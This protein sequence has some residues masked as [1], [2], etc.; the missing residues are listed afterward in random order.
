VLTDNFLVTLQLVISI[1][2]FKSSILARAKLRVMTKSKKVDEFGHL[3]FTIAYAFLINVVGILLVS[4]LSL[5]AGIIFFGAN[6]LLTLT[7]SVI[8]TLE[9]KSKLKERIIKD[10][11][12]I[13]VLVLGGVLPIIGVY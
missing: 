9:E 11:F 7:Y 6:I 12:F 8:M 13:L 3:T 5:Q 4:L 2:L 10:L 1:P